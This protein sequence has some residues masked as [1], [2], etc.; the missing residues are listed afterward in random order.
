MGKKTDAYSTAV[1][2]YVNQSTAAKNQ[3]NLAIQNYAQLWA[4]FT[5]AEQAFNRGTG[6]A[7]DMNR[8]L[9]AAEKARPAIQKA[10]DTLK[11]HLKTL[12]AETEKFEKYIKEKKLLVKLNPLKGKDSMATAELTIQYAKGLIATDSLLV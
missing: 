11:E 2:T 10:K 4:R 5:A 6:N 8:G 7:I 1:D 12:K 3:I 9:E